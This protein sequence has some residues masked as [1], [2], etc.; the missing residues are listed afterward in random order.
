MKP[1]QIQ[2]NSGSYRSSTPDPTNEV[3]CARNLKKQY[4]MSCFREGR[5]GFRYITGWLES[6][7]LNRVSRNPRPVSLAAESIPARLFTDKLRTI[8][9][10]D[11]SLLCAYKINAGTY[12]LATRL[13][14][15]PAERSYK[16]FPHTDA[17]LEKMQEQKERLWWEIY[18]PTTSGHLRKDGSY[19]VPKFKRTYTDFYKFTRANSEVLMEEYER[20]Q[21]VGY[22]V[23]KES[24]EFTLSEI[25][26]DKRKLEKRIKTELPFLIYSQSEGTVEIYFEEELLSSACQGCLEQFRSIEYQALECAYL[27]NISP[28]D[29][30][31]RLRTFFPFSQGVNVLFQLSQQHTAH[32]GKRQTQLATLLDIITKPEN[33]DAEKFKELWKQNF[34]MGKPLLYE[35]VYKDILTIFLETEE[36]RIDSP[37]H[38]QDPVQE[39]MNNKAALL[40]NEICRC[41]PRDNIRLCNDV[42]F[43]TYLPHLFENF[44]AANLLNHVMHKKHL[45][46]PFYHF[47]SNNPITTAVH[48]MFFESVADSFAQSYLNGLLFIPFKSAVSFPDNYHQYLL[49][50]FYY[51]ADP[52]SHWERL[53]ESVSKCAK[54]HPSDYRG[55]CGEHTPQEYV[56]SIKTLWHERETHPYTIAWP[57]KFKRAQEH[58]KRLADNL[59]PYPDSEKY[60]IVADKSRDNVLTVL[61]N[62]LSEPPVL[63][64]SIGDNEATVQQIL[65]HYYRRPGP[66]RLERALYTEPGLPVWKPIH[67]CSHVLR[68]RNNVR[69][70]MEY[71]E[72]EKLATFTDE[73]QE[74]L[75]LAAI[76]QD[77]AAEDVDKSL[78]EKRSAEYFC[79]DMSKHFSPELVRLIAQALEQ[80]EDDISRKQSKITDE[81]VRLYLRVLRFGDRMDAVRFVQ[82]GPSFPEWFTAAKGGQFNPALLD[83]P[84]S[85]VSSFVKEPELKPVCQQRLEAA[86]HGAVNLATVTGPT[87]IDDQRKPAPYVQQ[88]RLQPEANRVKTAFE[89][90]PHAVSSMDRFVD[91]NVRRKLA[92][93]GGIATCDDEEHSICCADTSTG[94]TKGIH[95]SWHDL[96]QVHLPDG[97]TLL[98]KMQCSHDV[99]CLKDTLR[100]NLASEAARLKQAGI[101]MSLG[102]LTQET[103]KSPA[104]QHV[105]SGRGYDVISQKRKRGFNEA[106]EQLWVNMFRPCKQ[107]KSD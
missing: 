102:T 6:S 73:E 74:L 49:M 72:L 48:G 95:N 63:T 96:A 35:N 22:V 27:L 66:E 7:Y 31:Y 16:C 20:A 10:V 52:T 84:S 89:R 91:D 28:Q 101:I 104:A 83:L 34:P 65:R 47:P 93:M 103:L 36:K 75:G 12:L 21:I 55:M 11:P 105:L 70:Y 92:Q 30:S 54:K 13:D 17:L 38:I 56:D 37:E 58:F 71:L 2:S 78:E 94:I 5:L 59:K 69:W 14:I 79:R 67:S 40:F 50:L 90:T 82:A 80:K 24:G 100:Q 41:I 15:H 45:N 81:R 46:V 62:A 86:M 61:R 51:G 53:L 26:F 29:L 64:G 85:L 4:L 33:Y 107:K 23:N 32:E 18:R 77:A 43:A 68:V 42:Y 19:S 8:A 106:G 76:Y 25:I 39:E 1:L 44:A 3:I 9:I 60:D 88:Y 57:E 98:E 87:P 97:M 99:Q